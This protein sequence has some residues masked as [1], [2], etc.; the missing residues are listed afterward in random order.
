MYVIFG[1]FIIT[2]LVCVCNCLSVEKLLCCGKYS[3][4]FKVGEEGE[5]MT[6]ENLAKQIIGKKK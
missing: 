6:G 4:K 5:D 1:L 2:T 3:S